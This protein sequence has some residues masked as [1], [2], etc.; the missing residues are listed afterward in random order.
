MKKKLPAL[1]TKIHFKFYPRLKTIEL[2]KPHIRS[3]PDFYKVLIN[4]RSKR[5]F[6]NKEISIK[7]LSSLLYYSGGVVHKKGSNLDLT[8]RTY[9]SAGAR[10][11]IEIYPIIVNVQDI[12][13]G[14]YHYNVLDNKLEFLLKGD[15]SGEMP[16][17]CNH[18]NWLEKANIYIV[19][20][21]VFN[22]NLV[23][24][25]QRGLR[26]IFMEA[27]HVGQNIYLNS[28]VLGLSCCAI[29]GFNDARLNE[30]LDIDGE[31]ESAIYLLAI[32]K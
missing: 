9:P 22:R 31:N 1:W 11:P 5:D 30:L 19:L 24:Y 10:Y 28:T 18:Q 17:I 12:D 23:K 32:G 8:R 20:S 2:P 21:A 7:E 13:K 26:Y 16:V 6:Q 27:G 29:G 25:K 4:R 15:Y 14:I 3:N